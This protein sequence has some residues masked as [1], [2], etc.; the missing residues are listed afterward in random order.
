MHN[1]AY[2]QVRHDVCCNVF[3]P[4]SEPLQCI[5][6]GAPIFLVKKFLVFSIP[7]SCPSEPKRMDTRTD[8]H[9]IHFG[10]K[11]PGMFTALRRDSERWLRPDLLFFCSTPCRRLHMASIPI[12]QHSSDTCRPPAQFPWI[13][14][15]GGGFQQTLSS[16]T[17]PRSCFVQHSVQTSR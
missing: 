11:H 10:S 6:S 17:S 12:Q 8:C 5:R 14:G 15:Q 2:Y 9:V 13:A 16:S 1:G 4:R 7:G 3:K